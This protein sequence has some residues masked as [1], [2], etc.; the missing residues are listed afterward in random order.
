MCHQNIW[1]C[2][3]CPVKY[4][5]KISSLKLKSKSLILSLWQLMSLLTD[6][7]ITKLLGKDIVID[8]FDKDMLTPV[9]YDFRVGDFVYSLDQCK[10]I[11]PVNGHYVL[12]PE[13]TIL[14]LTRESLW[15]SKRIGGLFHSKVS[16]VTQGLSH[17]ATTLDPNWFGPLLITFRNNNKTSFELPENAAFVTL[18]MFKV[19]TP[20]ETPHKKDPSRKTLLWAIMKRSP[21]N[22][23]VDQLNAQISEYVDKVSKAFT[24]EA[25]AHF[26]E[27][28]DQAKANSSKI[29][30]IK[31]TNIWGNLRR[32]TET[33]IAYFLIVLIVS[34]PL[35]FKDINFL[36]GIK[37]DSSFL[38]GQMT[39]I[40]AVVLFLLQRRSKQS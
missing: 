40:L 15:V 33:V 7:D 37:Y 12:P 38:A 22:Q 20:T 5:K 1:T 23:T 9:G 16:L 19:A 39:G 14:I 34:L 32:N 27:L 28:V 36:S 11:E 2:R 6:K 17:I 21:P 10:L 24:P 18:V 29:A 35:I 3:K 26:Q 25:Q 8:N 13:N 30:K 4:S 31:L